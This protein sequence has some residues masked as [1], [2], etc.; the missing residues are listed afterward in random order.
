MVIVQK[1]DFKAGFWKAF[2][3]RSNRTCA[4]IFDFFDNWKDLGLADIDKVIAAY[5]KFNMEFGY[6]YRSGAERF[7]C[8]AAPKKFDAAKKEF[9]T[10]AELFSNFGTVGGGTQVDFNE[11][12][13]NRNKKFNAGSLATGSTIAAPKVAV[14]RVYIV[15]ERFKISK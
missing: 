6:R 2:S 7:N 5:K 9:V 10:L 13:Y 3:D 15:P 8:V 1:T 14:G 12:F 4:T 11:E